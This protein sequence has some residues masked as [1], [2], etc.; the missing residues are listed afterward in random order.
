MSDVGPLITN[1]Q[2][3][4]I[5][6][7]QRELRTTTATILRL[8]QRV[9]DQELKAA[10]IR[11]QIARLSRSSF[12]YTEHSSL[13]EIRVRTFERYFWEN[14]YSL[15]DRA[16]SLEQTIPFSSFII[17]ESTEELYEQ[18]FDYQLDFHLFW[19]THLTIAPDPHEYFT[20]P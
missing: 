6:K 10:E 18:E 20:S 15:S 3:E 2:R 11:E 12:P 17:F 13:Y 14:Y 5:I 8:Q 19:E 4:L 7:L 1:C 16:I 9:V